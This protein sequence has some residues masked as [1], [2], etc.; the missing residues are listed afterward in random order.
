MA[1]KEAQAKW[2]DRKKKGLIA[3]NLICPICNKPCRSDSS[4]A[5]YHT[6]CCQKHTIEG[7]EYMKEMKRKSRAK[8][9]T[10]N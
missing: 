8:K 5:P 4:K 3:K 1:T 9:T 7:R 2:R 6:K 10:Y